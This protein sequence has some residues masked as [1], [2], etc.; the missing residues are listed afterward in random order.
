MILKLP[1]NPRLH[2]FDVCTSDHPEFDGYKI[3]G[4]SVNI[5]MRKPVQSVETY[6]IKEGYT[7]L[8]ELNRLY[9]GSEYYSI[10]LLYPKDNRPVAIEIEDYKEDEII[11]AQLVEKNIRE[12]NMRESQ[13]RIQ[14][15][16]NN[17]VN[18]PKKIDLDHFVNYLIKNDTE[19]FKNQDRELLLN[20]FKKYFNL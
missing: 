5:G 14:K 18:Y 7:Y 4:E 19:H 17:K 1:E 12:K 15:P 13:D 10:W 3:T 9:D 6:I 2:L 16:K 11:D 8:W 20:I